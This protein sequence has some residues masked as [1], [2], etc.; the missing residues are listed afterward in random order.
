MERQKDQDAYFDV[1]AKKPDFY[2]ITRQKT[3]KPK[4]QINRL[5]PEL[6]HRTEFILAGGGAGFS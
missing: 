4:S 6:L 2:I 5:F 1:H 3:G